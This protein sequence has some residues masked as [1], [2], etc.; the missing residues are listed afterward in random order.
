MHLKI[1]PCAFLLGSAVANIA[2]QPR[3]PHEVNDF[4]ISPR[5]VSQDG[6]KLPWIGEAQISSVCFP[7]QLEQC[8]GSQRYC[9]EKLWT[10]KGEGKQYSSEEECR[11]AREASGSPPESTEQGKE[12]PAPESLPAS[13]T[14]QQGKLPWKDPKSCRNRTEDCYGTELFCYILNIDNVEACLAARERDPSM[15]NTTAK[16][17]WFEGDLY[18]C[19]RVINPSERCYGTS[20][21]CTKQ[22]YPSGRYSSPEDC[23][24]ARQPRNKQPW[25]KGL[26]CK[27]RVESCMGTQAWCSS[28][29]KQPMDHSQECFSYREPQA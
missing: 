12:K 3:L 14:E 2:S 4:A 21:Y 18:D 26:G 6:K 22:M 16:M 10:A 15:V 9:H 1:I 28:L 11:T 7:G 29:P 24:A 8:T 20:T 25:I 13:S 27:K 23:L 19:G 17:K 5:A